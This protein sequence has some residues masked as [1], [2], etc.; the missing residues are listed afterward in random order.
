MNHDP[1]SFRRRLSH[2]IL[3]VLGA[4]SIA[5]CTSGGGP[6][7]VAGTGGSAAH[8]GSGGMRSTGMTSTGM[9]TG[10]GGMDGGRLDAGTGGGAGGGVG[11]GGAGGSGGGA[12]VPAAMECF[13]WPPDGGYPTDSDGGPD[14][15]PM[16]PFDAGP[17]TSDCPT[18]TALV[19]YEISAITCPG[20]SGWDPSKVLNGPTRNA[21]NQCCYAVD[22]RLCVNGGRPYLVDNRA[23]VSALVRG[24]RGWA[25]GAAPS[26]DGLGAD[27]RASLAEAWGAD[28]LQEHASV[29]S[30]SRFAL[31][32][33]AAGAPADLIAC[34]HQA[35]LDEIQHARLCFALA[36]AYAGEDVAPGP[37]PLG[38][39]VR[40][41]ARLAEVAASTVVE[42]CVG[43]TVAAV[44]AAEQLARAT[45][46][47]VRAALEQIAAEEARHAELAW[48]TVAWAV[49]TGGSE[50]RAAVA[51]AFLDA[52]GAGV[53]APTVAGGP[54]R[55]VQ[56]HGRLDAAALARAVA[57]AKAEIVAPAVRALLSSGQTLEGGQL[58]GVQATLYARC[59]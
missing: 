49:R 17:P 37:F 31:A 5:A 1:L 44:V 57:S 48:R 32:L 26:L 50:V 8:A 18:N 54:S 7:A 38:G 2:R 15:S 51:Q 33:L 16:L 24:E 34:A 56:A 58:A 41:G 52:L 40:V 20:G 22:L 29:A 59:P 28:G 46:P 47:A 9:T 3:G 36:S 25:E 6:A 23:R 13:D 4:T 14:A 10:A 30:F 43:E 11:S 12:I 19:I 39:E 27:E 53:D 42:G 35:A 21:E 55:A 45:D